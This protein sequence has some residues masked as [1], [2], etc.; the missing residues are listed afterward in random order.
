MRYLL[1]CLMFLVSCATSSS[2]VFNNQD[3]QDTDCY[4]RYGSAI[5][6]CD[7]IRHIGDPTK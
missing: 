6:Y 2:K 3:E 7:M 5:G 4:D 1:L